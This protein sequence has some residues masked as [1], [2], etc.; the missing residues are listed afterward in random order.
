MQGELG[1]TDF[2]VAERRIVDGRGVEWRLP[3]LMA[4]AFRSLA[5]MC[6]WQMGAAE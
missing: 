1:I 4:M 5:N 3:L 2:E 6:L